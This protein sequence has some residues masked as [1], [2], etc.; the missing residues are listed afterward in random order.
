MGA[1]KSKKTG[2]RKKAPRISLDAETVESLNQYAGEFLEKTA[3]RY[4][5]TVIQTQQRAAEFA[6]SMIEFQRATFDNTFKVVTRLQNRTEKA[7]DHRLNSNGW[8]PKEGKTL[9]REWERAAQK[10][11]VEFQRTVGRSFDLAGQY[12]TRLEKEV[13]RKQPAKRRVEVVGKG[14]AGTKV[15]QVLPGK[16]P[17]KAASKKKSRSASKD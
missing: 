12:L 8:V 9:V 2:S 6:L 7:I 5:V 13:S 11:R 15:A 10:A 4:D 16:K 3:E 14:L 1:S 17:R